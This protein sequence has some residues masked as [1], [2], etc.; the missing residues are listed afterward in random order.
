MEFWDI[1]SILFVCTAANHL[2]LVTAVETIIRHKLPVV[3]C[4]K[5]LTF[6]SVFVYG[7]GNA[8]T[9]GTMA[10]LAISFLSAWASIWLDLMMG[11]IDHIYI[12]V[13]EQIY[14]TADEADTDAL[15]ATDSVPDVLGR[16]GSSDGIA[17]NYQENNH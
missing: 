9:Y 15:S 1:A 8:T 6:W 3:N 10:V 12:K 16:E 7:C 11:V 13:Y 17:A 14:T 5:C 2:G 4:I